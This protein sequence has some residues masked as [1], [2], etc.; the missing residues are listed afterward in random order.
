MV[1]EVFSGPFLI[2]QGVDY[3]GEGCIG[4]V[5]ELEIDSCLVEGDSGHGGVVAE[6]EDRENEEDV[7]IEVVADEVGV[8][9]E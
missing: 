4:N 8:L 9:A 3:N 6:V 5:V 1:G 2:I 7:F